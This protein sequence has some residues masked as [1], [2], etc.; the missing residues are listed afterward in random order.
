MILVK[1]MPK[2]ERRL[3]Q[4]RVEKFLVGVF[5]DALLVTAFSLNFKQRL[6]IRNTDKEVGHKGNKGGCQFPM[7]HNCNGDKG[8]QVNHIFPRKYLLG[9]GVEN[10]D[11]KPEILLA[12]C[13]NSHIGD[14][15][16][17]KVKIDPVHPD[18]RDARKN[19]GKDKNGISK[20][21]EV[22]KEKQDE[23]V[24]WW[25]DSNRLDQKQ[26][27]QAIKNTEKMDKK[28][29]GRKIWWPW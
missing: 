1:T 13:T 26:I 21:I 10:P 5:A 16:L 7:K 29:G 8:L 9:M 14:P 20:A 27:V 23:R 28:K 18:I 2:D 19:Y 4:N 3:D 17:G 24:V 12:L 15:S 22:Q 6:A 11:N 25:N